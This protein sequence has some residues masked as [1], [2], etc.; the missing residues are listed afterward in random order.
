MSVSI[1]G[2]TSCMRATSASEIRFVAAIKVSRIVLSCFEL[3]HDLPF[4]NREVIVAH[5]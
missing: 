3:L 4:R 1:S 5:F 2:I